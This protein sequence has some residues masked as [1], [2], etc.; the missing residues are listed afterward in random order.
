MRKSLLLLSLSVTILS[1]ACGGG[2]APKLSPKYGFAAQV[3]AGQADKAVKATQ[4]AGFG[5][6]TQQVR[7]DGLEPTQGAA[8]EWNQ[9]DTAVN[10]ASAGGVKMM[11]S[12]VV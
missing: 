10:A 9:L 1:A 2:G 6:L 11:F 7:W 8:V 5:W 3:V 4:A 12:I